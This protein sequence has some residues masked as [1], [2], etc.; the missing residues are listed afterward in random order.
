MDD[1]EEIMKKYE[2]SYERP[3]DKGIN[4]IIKS[5]DNLISPILLKSK[6]DK[7]LVFLFNAK[8]KLINSDIPWAISELEK[9]LDKNTRDAI[10]KILS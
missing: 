1:Y 2:A 7:D 10:L 5:I 6:E 3:A 4:K 8:D 9:L